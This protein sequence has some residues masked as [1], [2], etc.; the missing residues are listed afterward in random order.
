MMLCFGF[1]TKTALLTHHF[2]LLLNSAC[3]ALRL[4][5]FLMLPPQP[6]NWGW[7]GD[8]EGT[9][10]GQLTLKVFRDW[11]GISLLVGL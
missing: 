4:S 9:Q 1:E 8:W 5:L 3:T 10:S 7:A 6:V 2:Q 11:L